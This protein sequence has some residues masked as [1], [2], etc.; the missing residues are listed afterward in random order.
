MVLKPREAEVLQLLAEGKPTKVIAG[1]LDVSVKTVDSHRQNLM[2]KL[3]LH[4]VAELTKFA[5]RE[6]MTSLDF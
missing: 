5:I 1:I 2:A 3:D 6:G 4:S